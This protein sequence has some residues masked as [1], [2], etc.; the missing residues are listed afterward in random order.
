MTISNSKKPFCASKEMHPLTLEALI[1]TC[2]K[3]KSFVVDFATST[4]MYYYKHFIDALE[5]HS[6][7]S[8]NILFLSNNSVLVSRNSGRHILALDGDQEVF[9]EVFCLFF[10]TKDPRVK[11][12]QTFPRS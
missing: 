5:F 11:N 9:D 3:L 4:G 12:C 7:I 1:G 2:S 8:S 10:K 6:R